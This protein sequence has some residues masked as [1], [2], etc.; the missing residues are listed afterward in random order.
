MLK[1]EFPNESHREMYEEML[2]KWKDYK[3]PSESENIVDKNFSEFLS[4]A[5]KSL[6]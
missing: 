5:E 3:I 4:Y 2:Q 6:E 1:L